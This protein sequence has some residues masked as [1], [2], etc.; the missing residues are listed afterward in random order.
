MA[1]T[2]SS[3]PAAH[4]APSG[5]TPRLVVTGAVLA[6]VGALAMAASGSGYR[7]QVWGLGVAFRML[8]FGAV[9]AGMGGIAAAIALLSPT[10]RRRPRVLPIAAVSLVAAVIAVGTFGSWFMTARSVPGIHDIT[11]DTDNP[12]AFVA[13][14]AARLA[15]P[16]GL[17]YGG[18]EVAAKQRTGYPDIQPVVLSIPPSDAYR[19]ALVVARSMGWDIAAADSAAGRI[20]ATATTA[21]Y[22]FR[23]DV[24]IRVR[25]DSTG[26][27][28][29]LRSDSRLGGSDVGTNA[30]RIRRFVERIKAG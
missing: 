11:T 7:M 4:N 6:G 30:A 9:L 8:A 29:D 22:G 25:P 12:P 3:N 28:L 17:D 5:P 26:T 13:L 14:R 27:R 19:R 18:A 15:A 23:D 16:N 20:E 2:A 21:W 10:L 1:T 24:V